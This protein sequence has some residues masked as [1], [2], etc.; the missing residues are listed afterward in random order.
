[1]PSKLTPS[2]MGMSQEG[3]MIRRWAESIPLISKVSAGV[4]KPARPNSGRIRLKIRNEVGC[5]FVS[6]RGRTTI[7]EMRL[8]GDI[9]GMRR[10]LA[11]FCAEQN[12]E[13]K[14]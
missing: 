12:F 10:N 8:Y 2:H 11:A 13:L 7:Q 5:L 1:M 9:Q 3:T 14:G 4:I 6:I